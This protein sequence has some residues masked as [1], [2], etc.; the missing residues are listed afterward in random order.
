[1]TASF[2]ALPII[3]NCVAAVALLIFVLGMER[4]DK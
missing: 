4:S 2:E 1:M 3:V